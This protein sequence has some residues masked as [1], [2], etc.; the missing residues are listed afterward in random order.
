MNTRTV[1]PTHFL[2][3]ARMRRATALFRV[4]VSAVVLATFAMTTTGCGEKKKKK[5]VQNLFSHKP[6]P[7]DYSSI[8]VDKPKI[9]APRPKADTWAA[10]M[11]DAVAAIQKDL[12]RCRNEF[13][14]PFQFRKMR[15]RNVEWLKLS[16][17]D[18]VCRDGDRTRKQ[19]G[20]WRRVSWLAKEHIGKR[21][22]LDRYIAL[23]ADHVEHARMV[24]LMAKKIGAPKIELITATA[25]TS[26]DR[27]ITAGMEL[28]RLAGE[29]AGWSDDLAP[30]DAPSEVAKAIDKDAFTKSLEQHYTP[31]LDDTLGAYDRFASESWQYPNMIKFKSLRLWAEVLTKYLQTDRARIDKVTGV[32][33]KSKAQLTAYLAA[34]ETVV[35]AWTG[36]YKRY[37][38][39]KGDTWTDVDPFRPPLAKAWIAWSKAHDGLYGTSKEKANKAS[40]KAWKRAD[41]KRRRGKK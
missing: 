31:F 40:Y 18:A 22:K 35:K 14:V 19:R 4:G 23:A 8:K 7:I 15:R 2:L 25:K 17:M 21:P 6:K 13:M 1:R 26:R 10:H 12:Q 5:K 33:D 36:S 28:D 38:K 20:P 16:V 27:V 9:E 32:D 30:L 29:I 24:S 39:N 37:M 11:K 3:A 34:V 41:R